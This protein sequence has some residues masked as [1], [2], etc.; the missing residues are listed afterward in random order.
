MRDETRFR[1]TNRPPQQDATIFEEIKT[2]YFWY[3]DN[4]HK[5]H[6][7]VFNAIE[8]HIGEANLNGEI[9]ANSKIKGRKM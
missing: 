2:R 3:I 1:K 9:Q 5:D 6:F 7:E 8:E 4:L